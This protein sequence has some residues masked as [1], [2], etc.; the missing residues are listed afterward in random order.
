[1]SVIGDSTRGS[2]AGCQLL[3]LEVIQRLLS[4]ACAF[5][6]DQNEGRLRAALLAAGKF[7]GCGSHRSQP[8][9]V[10]LT[11]EARPAPLP[12]SPAGRVAPICTSKPLRTSTLELWGS[13][14]RFQ[15]EHFLWS[16][17]APDAY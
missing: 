9:F 17:N 14:G 8:N 11:G 6:G 1:M 4:A 16:G 5:K 7:A 3:R 10:T 2:S 13:A 15:Q 12:W